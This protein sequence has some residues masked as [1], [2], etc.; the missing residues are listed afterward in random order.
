M[1]PASWA[2]DLL[3]RLA[4]SLGE[5]LHVLL[6]LGQKLVQRRIQQADGHGQV[7]HLPEQGEHVLPL[8]FQQLVQ[9]TPPLVFVLGEDHGAHDVD[10]VAVEEH[11]LGAA[12]ADALG[13][14]FTRL[15]GIFRG[16]GVGANG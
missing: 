7:A 2:S 15:G 14:E 1:K 12:Q 4:D 5:R 8:E 6:A 9:V 16:F 3:N 11:V 13:A 10:A